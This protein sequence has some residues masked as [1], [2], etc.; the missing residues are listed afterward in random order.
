M[1]RHHVLIVDDEE[2]IR[3]MLTLILKRAEYNVDTA[4]DGQEA[5]EKIRQGE[6][7]VVLCDVRMPG[8]D[9]LDLL[10][11]L[12]GQQ[13]EATILMMSAYGDVGCSG[14]GSE[15]GVRLPRQALPIRR[16]ASHHTEG[17]GARAPEA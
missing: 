17:R 11:E 2:S 3:H 8:R 13:P 7:D 16:A 5:L 6:Y 9:G 10:P 15:G 4:V 14:S 12:V 1:T